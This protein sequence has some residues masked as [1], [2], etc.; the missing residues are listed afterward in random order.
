MPPATSPLK[1]NRTTRS[2]SRSTHQWLEARATGSGPPE[3]SQNEVDG[4]MP[5]RAKGTGGERNDKHPQIILS[6]Y[7]RG[8]GFSF[9]L[10]PAAVGSPLFTGFQ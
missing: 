10:W 7:L 4:R 1:A 5:D 6:G 8:S 3:Q 2:L 9:N